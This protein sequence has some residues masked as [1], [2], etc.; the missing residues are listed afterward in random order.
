SSLVISEEVA[1]ALRS[2]KAVVALES[3][4]IS[5]GMPYP[6]NL[7]TACE[8]EGVVREGGAIPATVA[9]IGG[10]AKVGL[11]ADD[12]VA[13]ADP[14]NRV[15]KCSRRD[16]ALAIASGSHGATTVAGTA[17]LA[18][19]AGIVVFATGGIGGVH[20]GGE[21]SLD[22]SADL[23]EL[24]RTPVAVICA[25]IKSILDIRRT[26]EVL[27]TQGVPV[28]SLGTDEFPAFFN[29]RSNVPTPARLET[30]ADVAAGIFASRS[31]GL[32][33]GMV[34]AIPPQWGGGGGSSS[35]SG[36]G[37][38]IEA[39]VRTALAEAAAGAAIGAGVTPFVLKR[40]AELTGS[41]SLKSNV[42]LIKRNAAAAA[43]IAV[44]LAALEQR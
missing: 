7:A 44:H 2:G 8:V 32:E 4:I 20:R 31:L 16:I 3:T 29:T 13:L 1:C 10:T 19:R 41:R 24:S 43:E 34:V 35:S 22:I 25:G 37:E 6:Q 17:M 14:S 28:V 5:H 15:R 21:L 40:V 42:T 11:D 30:T 18:H 12:L 39:A 27:E 23:V 38:E 36:D 26:L 33:N 9:I